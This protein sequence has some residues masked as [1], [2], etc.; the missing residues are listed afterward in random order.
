MK[1][2]LDDLQIRHPRHIISTNSHVGTT[3]C[4]AILIGSPDSKYIM[5]ITTPFTRPLFHEPHLPFA[6]GHELIES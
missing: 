6:F 5:R 1:T 3:F 4:G 2:V